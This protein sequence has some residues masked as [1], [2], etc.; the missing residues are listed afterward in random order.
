MEK[1]LLDTDILSE[2]L[3]RRDQRVVSR[4]IS[5]LAVFGRYTICTITVLEIV[6]GWHRLQRED[7]IQQFFAQI[8]VAEV[9]TLQLRDAELAGR[10]YADL[11]RIGQPIGLADSMIAAIAIQQNLI[12]VTGNLAHYQRIQALGYSLKL[13][14]WRI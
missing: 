7:R 9:L 6:K 3:K 12:L 8:A 11:E 13:D 10:I 14:N 2:S 5:Y 1:V 4:A